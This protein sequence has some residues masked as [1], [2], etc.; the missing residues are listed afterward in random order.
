MEVEVDVEQDVGMGMDVD[1]DVKEEEKE[2]KVI[3]GENGR[4][5]G[6]EGKE[7]RGSLP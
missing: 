5:I 3:E 7:G 4:R 2:G 1:V 6:A